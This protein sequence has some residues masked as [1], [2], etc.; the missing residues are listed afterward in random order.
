MA[1]LQLTLKK[2]TIIAMVVTLFSAIHTAQAEEPVH[3]FKMATGWAG[4]P[5]STIGAQAFADNVEQI[6]NGRIKVQVFTGGALGNALKVSET[7]KNGVAEMGHTWMGYDWGKDSTTVLF[8]GYAGSPDSERMLHWLYQGGGVELQREFREEKFE[9]IS[10]PLFI[11]TAEVFLHSRK[12]VKTLEDLQGLKLRTA[13]AWLEMSAS[14]G[15]AP[16][17]TPGGDV[18]PMLERGAIDATEWGTPWENISPGFHKVA[19]YVIIPGIHQPVA[20]FELVINKTA[21]GTL[22][23]QDKQAVETAAK[24]TTLNSWLRIGQEDAKAMKFYV[25]EGNEIIELD[26]EVQFKA[27]EIAKTW[28]EKQAT[29]NEWFA[30]VYKNQQEFL[31]LWEDADSYRKV[32]TRK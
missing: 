6:S 5:L 7:V 10:F 25:A 16:V 2:F 21:W 12:P 28:A 19:K 15:A 18:Y 4:G 17:T 9:V 27:Q 14:L 29:D 24:L 23:D 8:G 11:R 22:S 31:A 26:P 13:G 30:R 32:L 20:P 3:N 1:S